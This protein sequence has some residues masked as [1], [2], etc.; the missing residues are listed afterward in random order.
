MK[1]LFVCIGNICRSPCAHAILQNLQ[2]TWEIESAGTHADVYMPDMDFRMKEELKKHNISFSHKPRQV[3]T[4]DIEYYDYIF[5]MA[6]DNYFH[7]KMKF[8]KKYHHKIQFLREFDSL[9]PGKKNVDDPYYG[10]LEGFEIA[11]EIIQR[12][13]Q[14]IAK[15]LSI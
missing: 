14:H 2:P 1:V 5:V 7:L 12:C 4:Q 9:D 6:E 10:G 15:R 13:C 8:D 11:F 3:T